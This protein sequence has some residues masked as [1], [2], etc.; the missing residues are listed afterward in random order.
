[1]I[2]PQSTRLTRRR[3]TRVTAE[4]MALAGAVALVLALPL[5]SS[6]QSN[7]CRADGDVHVCRTEGFG[8]I[9]N[10][11]VAQAKGEAEI[12][13]RRR[14]VEQVAGV[15]VDTETVTRNEVLFDD[16]V[17][18]R[19]AGLIR[20]DRIVEHGKTSDGS[21]YRVLLEAWVT[22]QAVNER[23]EE[24]VSDLSMVV[25]VA[26]QNMGR[27]QTPSVIDND[28]VSALVAGGYRVLD[29]KH[30]RRVLKRDEL[31][32]L[33][34]A[35]TRTA[36][37]IRLRFLA[38]LIVYV[39]AST[40]PSQNTQGIISAHARASARIVEAET[41]R[42]VAN[43]ALEEVKGFAT[44]VDIAGQRALRAA[45]KPLAEEIRLGMDGYFK[46][47]ERAIE[48]RLRNLP[49]LD[50]YRR[51]KQFLEQQR[52]VS[53]VQEGGYAP[54]TALIRVIYPEKTLY[55]ASRL[56]RE[57]RYR[58]VEFDRNRILVEFRR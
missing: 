13:A 46:R 3:W 57:A 54:D 2:Y 14:A 16:I 10:N 48:V 18:T 40:Q 45:G 22:T 9:L 33:E 42:V 49:S 41:A 44:S 31:A 1:M 19:S 24:L 7:A 15:R 23:L 53:G 25:L 11:D 39:D 6:A 38:N 20:N 17:R 4:A 58:L 30:L 26:E 34:R 12:D 21:Q 8:T 56:E 43:V 55:L 28:L 36:R 32:A 5:L 29:P 37:D 27:P 35:D 51:A 52:W 47:K 50:E